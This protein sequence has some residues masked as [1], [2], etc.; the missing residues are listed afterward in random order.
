MDRRSYLSLLAGLGLSAGFFS[1]VFALALVAKLLTQGRLRLL[2]LLAFT[3]IAWAGLRLARYALRAAA[4]V[5]DRRPEPRPV[6]EP[7]GSS[8][9]QV[10]LLARAAKGRLSATEVAVATGLTVDASRDVL[11]ALIREGVAEL[12]LNDDGGFVYAFPEL[13]EGFKDGA[14]SPLAP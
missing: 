1:A 9:G 8:A 14:K 6:P 5:R 7:S 12:W 11:E 2:P 4:E 13:L 10:M 3:L